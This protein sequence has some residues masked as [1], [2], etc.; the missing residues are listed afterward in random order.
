MTRMDAMCLE[1]FVPYSKVEDALSA[2]RMEGVIRTRAP[3]GSRMRLLWG[4]LQAG[5]FCDLEKEGDMVDPMRALD[6]AGKLPPVLLYHSKDDEAVPWQRTEAW[7]AK[8]KSLQPDVELYLTYQK[9]E[10]VFDKNDTLATP[11]LK[12]PLEFVRRYWPA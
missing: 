5:K 7:A 2:A 10:H 1:E 6:Y 9:G 11:W 3:F 8:L 4:L 12:G